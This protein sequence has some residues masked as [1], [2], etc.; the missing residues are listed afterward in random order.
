MEVNDPQDFA[1]G[2]ANERDRLDDSDAIHEADR[3]AVKQWMRSKD[4]QVA[5]SSLKTYLRRVRV[6]SE[7]ADRPAR[8]DE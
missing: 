6:A 3:T 1:A 2:L 7:R 4:G 5:V 8:R